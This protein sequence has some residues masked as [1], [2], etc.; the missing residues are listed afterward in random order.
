MPIQPGS[1]K[2]GLS[3][4]VG[5]LKLATAYYDFAVDGGAIGNITLRG[6]SLPSG[7][8]IVDSVIKVDTGVTTASSGTVALK[9]EG[10]GDLRAA[11]TPA[12]G[13]PDIHA[14]GVFRLTNTPIKTTAVRPIVATVATGAI[15]AGKFSVT[16]VFYE[17][18]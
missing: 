7:A 6:D 16:V 17:V 9:S 18:A 15:T 14:A 3:T 11:G 13:T 2:T 1:F 4:Q 12:D 10:T 8:I 5:L